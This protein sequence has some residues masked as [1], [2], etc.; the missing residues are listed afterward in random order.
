MFMS[1]NAFVVEVWLLSEGE[2]DL[3]LKGGSLVSSSIKDSCSLDSSTVLGLKKQQNL[4]LLF[5]IGT[6]KDM[7]YSY[8][9]MVISLKCY[10]LEGT[11]IRASNS[12]N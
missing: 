11:L 10:F 2:C 12:N 7:K 1:F 4:H 8:N 6:I 3:C 5:V 9:I